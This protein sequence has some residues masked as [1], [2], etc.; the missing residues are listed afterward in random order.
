MTDMKGGCC[1]ERYA[2]CSIVQQDGFCTTI[3]QM[4][5]GSSRWRKEFDITDYLPR[6]PEL[7][8]KETSATLRFGPPDA[9]GC[10]SECLEAQWCPDQGGDTPGHHHCLMRSMPHSCQASIQALGDHTNYCVPF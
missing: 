2:T 3:R 6:L 1:G 9:V 5:A 10:I 4:H 8:P 7:N